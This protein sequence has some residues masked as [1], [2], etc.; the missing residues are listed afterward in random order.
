MGRIFLILALTLILTS[1]AEASFGSS[2]WGFCAWAFRQ[3]VPYRPARSTGDLSSIYGF[4]QKHNPELT[5]RPLSETETRLLKELFQLGRDDTALV[6]LLVDFHNPQNSPTAL[7]DRLQAELTLLRSPR[8]GVVPLDQ[9]LAIPG[10]EPLQRAW[11]RFAPKWRAEVAYGP[12]PSETAT[13]QMEPQH[14]RLRFRPVTSAE[15][16]P[17]V[18][19][20]EVIHIQQ[21]E[22]VLPNEQ[23]ILSWI[24]EKI[25]KLQDQNLDKVPLIERD[26]AY[27]WKVEL[28]RKAIPD[29]NS[30]YVVEFLMERDTLTQKVELYKK[31]VA[32]RP[33]YRTRRFEEILASADPRKKITELINERFQLSP[34]MLAELKNF[35][36]DDIVRMEGGKPIKFIQYEAE[37]QTPPV[38]F[39]TDG[40]TLL[41]NTPAILQREP[42]YGPELERQMRALPEADLRG[43][44]GYLQSPEMARD[45]YAYEQHLKSGKYRPKA[46]EDRDKF[47]HASDIYRNFGHTVLLLQEYDRHHGTHHALTEGVSLLRRLHPNRGTADHQSLVGQ[48]T[49]AVKES[50]NPEAARLYVDALV[51]SPIQFGIMSDN[52]HAVGLLYDLLARVEVP[53][54]GAAKE[55]ALL[56]PASE[57]LETYF[58]DFIAYHQG[59]GQTAKQKPD[60]GWHLNY[61][62]DS[63]KSAQVYFK[64]MG[65]EERAKKYEQR[66]SKLREILN[67]LLD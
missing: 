30:R 20:E 35:S 27:Q 66:L 7:Q 1:P 16:L 32:A 53:G 12:L 38:A 10:W 47:S 40:R 24:K 58:D 13:A 34:E 4:A 9:W 60:K 15:P 21:L 61:A 17:L 36:L 41:A 22:L 55:G 51:E 37:R 45:P 14:R 39:K 50:K 57:K 29:G 46:E 67:I 44:I 23:R 25:L 26:W 42:S 18:A 54:K 28:L 56:P 33:E 2:I 62:I 43:L 31:L 3:V 63:A 11:N 52:Q 65:D 59:I 8:K 19:A 64:R 5:S 6:A 49:L 48:I